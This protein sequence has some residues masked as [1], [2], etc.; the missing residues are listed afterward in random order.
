MFNYD[1]AFSRNI[2]WVTKDE[3]K[4]L[5][6]KRIA[7]AGCGGVGGEHIV[8]LARLGIGAFNIADFDAFEE[9][10]LN[11][12]AGAFSSTIGSA[13]CQV[14]RDVALDIN[15]EIY[16]NTF[17]KGVFNHNVDAFL[18][19]VDIYIDSLDFFALDA[20]KCIFNAC[21]QKRIP[22][23]TVAPLG[24]GAAFLCFMPDK[25][26]FE[27]YFRFEDKETEE[28]QLLQFLIGLSPALLQRDYLVDRSSADFEA[29]KGPSLGLSVKLCAGVAAANVLKIL[30]KRGKVLAAPQGLHFDGYKNV[31]KQTHLRSGNRCILQKIKF[32][33]AK[34]IVST[35]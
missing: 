32:K 20:R 6:R 15:P 10:N 8:T 27:E 22:I 2:G 1:N 26:S 34:H 16:I 4:T 35:D 9:H 29:Q 19:G 23:I 5:Q 21:E 31:L 14:M 28:E 24:M 13:K 33:V 30:L 12:Q 17:D 11:R 18:D 7:I 3:Q 25:M